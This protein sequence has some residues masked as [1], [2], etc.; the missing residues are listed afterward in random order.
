MTVR[1]L[2]EELRNFDGDMK[3]KIG[4]KQRYG[5]DFAMDVEYDVEERKIRAFWGSNYKAVVITQGDQCGAV[6]YNDYEDDEDDWDEDEE[7]D[8]E[9]EE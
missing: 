5:T 4:M 8:W 6:V 7:D 9:D 3:V 2:I 1:E